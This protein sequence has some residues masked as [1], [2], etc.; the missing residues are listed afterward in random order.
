MVKLR[1][2][3]SLPAEFNLFQLEFTLK[4]IQISEILCCKRI[5]PMVLKYYACLSV[6]YFSQRPRSSM[7]NL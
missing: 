6:D 4:E 5:V 7:I 1:N 2:W 3:W